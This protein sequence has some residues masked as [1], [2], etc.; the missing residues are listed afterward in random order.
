MVCHGWVHRA[1]LPSCLLESIT[2]PWKLP[3]EEG[4][5][6]PLLMTAEQMTAETPLGA[7]LCVWDSSLVQSV[8]PLTRQGDG[9]CY[10]HFIDKELER[11][12]RDPVSSAQVSELGCEAPAG[13]LQGCQEE[14]EI[15]PLG[16]PCGHL[17]QLPTVKNWKQMGS[18]I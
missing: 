9:I 8:Q 1:Q 11:L 6:P 16:S 18:A 15:C 13:W 12:R 14:G 4:G 5:K 10:V 17:T 7:G 2:D 3:S